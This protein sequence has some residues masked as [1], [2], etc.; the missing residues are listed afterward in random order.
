MCTFI[1]FPFIE[2]LNNECNRW[3]LD[4]KQTTTTKR[5]FINPLHCRTHWA[6][7]NINGRIAFK[8]LFY[9]WFDL[10]KKKKNFVFEFQALSDRVCVREVGITVTRTTFGWLFLKRHS[11][12]NAHAQT[13]L[14][15]CERDQAV[16]ISRANAFCVRHIFFTLYVPLHFGISSKRKKEKKK[17][18]K[19]SVNARTRSTRYTTLYIINTFKWL[20]TRCERII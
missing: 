4:S 8:I 14:Q 18:W 13:Q 2:F 11:R 19:L 10:K 15:E 1:D 3:A 7:M 17:L 20:P 6:F 12:L 16:N 5:V 9:F